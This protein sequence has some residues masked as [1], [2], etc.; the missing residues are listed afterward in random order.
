MIGIF[1]PPSRSCP[2]SSQ[3]TDTETD[4]D[5]EKSVVIEEISMHED[6]PDELAHDLIFKAL[7]ASISSERTRFENATRS[8]LCAGKT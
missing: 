6:N 4:L 3:I 7:W 5:K 2:T 8:E 1:H